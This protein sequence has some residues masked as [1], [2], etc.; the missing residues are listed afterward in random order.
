[1]ALTNLNTNWVRSSYYN[2]RDYYIKYLENRPLLIDGDTRYL[3]PY[4]DGSMAIGYGFDLLVHS[5]VQ[6]N[7]FFADAGLS[8]SVLLGTEPN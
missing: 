5:D 8:M 3:K 2:D 4:Y 7:K 6:I 1:M